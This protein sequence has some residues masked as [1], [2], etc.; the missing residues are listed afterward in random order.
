MINEQKHKHDWKEKDNFLI[1]ACGKRKLRLDFTNSDVAVGIK[2]D[3][4]KYKVRTNR[5]KI[6]TPNEWLIFF[7]NL[8]A[9]QQFTFKFLLI[10]GARINEAQNVKVEDIDFNNQ[11][12]VLRITKQR[13]GENIRNKS[14]TRTLRVSS[15]LIKEIKKRIKL[16]ELKKEDYLKIL[17]QPAAHIALKKTLQLSKIKD[18]DM[19]SVHSIR[20]TSENWAL[21]LHVDSMFLST[22]FGH[23]LV[24]QYEH[25]SQSQA[26]TLEEVNLIKQIFGDTFI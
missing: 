18:Y 4:R 26:Y 25:Y 23:N 17:S 3:G 21:A 12:V 13:G 8:K 11:R 6:F 1:C 15:E 19:L 2:S 24:T 16:L 5:D 7:S 9:S 10:T 14:K 22:R 20:K